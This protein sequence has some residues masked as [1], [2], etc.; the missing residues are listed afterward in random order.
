MHETKGIVD[1]GKPSK[2]GNGYVLLEKTDDPNKFSLRISA[3]REG[4]QA[5]KVARGLGKRLTF[6]GKKL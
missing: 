2:F 1:V 6:R 5:R 4:L 3:S